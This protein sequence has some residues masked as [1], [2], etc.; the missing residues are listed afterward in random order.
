MKKLGL[1]ATMVLVAG[2]AMGLNVTGN[3]NFTGEINFDGSWAIKGTKVGSSATELNILDGITA[4]TAQL[5]T[6]GPL[7]ALVVTNVTKS[8][9]AV[10]ATS[11]LTMHRPGAVTPT[12]TMTLFTASLTNV[13]DGV[14]NVFLVVTNATAASSALPDFPTNATAEV[15][16]VGGAAVVTNITV[17][18]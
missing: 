9:G 13:V 11:A 14:T 12:I 8:T 1:F 3:Q 10:T 2:L 17:Q 4:T 6:L 7:S 16:V 5:N 15:T 18:R